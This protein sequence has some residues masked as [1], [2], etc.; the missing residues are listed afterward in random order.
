MRSSRSSLTSKVSCYTTLLHII[1][2]LICLETYLRCYYSDDPSS[3]VVCLPMDEYCHNTYFHSAIQITPYK[4]LYGRPYP[5]HLPYLPGES[6][7]AKFDTTFINKELKLQ[8]FKHY[9]I[10]AQ[11]RMKH[12]GNVHRSDRSF[13]VGDQVYFKVQPFKQAIIFNHSSH[14]LAVK[15]YGSFQIIKKVVP[16]AYTLRQPSSIKI[17]AIVYVSLIKRCFA[18]P[19]IISHPLT[20]DLANPNCPMPKATLQRRMVKGGKKLQLKYWLNGAIYLLMWLLENL[21][22]YLRLDFLHLILEDKDLSI[23]E[24]IVIIN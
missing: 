4:F 8:L 2:S 5:L 22:Q 10:R 13:L 7:S 24:S 23:G 20:I 1:L 16:V 19:S 9:L 12:Q 17:H 14:K 6:A 3:W 15:Y 18:V 11:H 21:L